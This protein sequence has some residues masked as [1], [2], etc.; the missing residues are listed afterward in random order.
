MQTDDTL[1]A[2]IRE[3]VSR[4]LREDVGDGD[5]TAQLIPASASID[6]TIITRES[7]TMAGR[8]WVDEVCRQVD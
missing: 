5:L 3:S 6:A 1:L 2:E 7:M 4:A 8:P